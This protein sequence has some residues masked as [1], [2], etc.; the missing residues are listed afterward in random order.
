MAVPAHPCAP[1][2]SY[3]MYIARWKMATYNRVAM[4]SIL[5]IPG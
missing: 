1:R 2:H 5:H 4:F 3:L